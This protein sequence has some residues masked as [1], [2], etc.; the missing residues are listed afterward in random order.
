MTLLTNCIP[1]FSC[2]K[3]D[4]SVMEPIAI[5]HKLVSSL[6][7]SDLLKASYSGGNLLQNGSVSLRNL[8]HK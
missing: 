2:N 8:A 4:Y 7:G 3:D 5:K 1:F 6:D